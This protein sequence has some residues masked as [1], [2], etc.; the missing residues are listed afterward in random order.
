MTLGP[1]SHPGRRRCH[2]V[3]PDGRRD[4]RRPIGIAVIMVQPFLIATSLAAGAVGIGVHAAGR[5][6]VESTRESAS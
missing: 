4:L 2:H 6:H 3:S 5:W 1:R